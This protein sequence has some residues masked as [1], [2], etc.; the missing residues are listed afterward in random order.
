MV[1]RP[2]DQAGVVELA[3]V[4]LVVA[5]RVAVVHRAVAARRG[6]GDGVQQG[7]LRSDLGCHPRSGATYLR[8]NCLRP[9]A[10]IAGIYPYTCSLGERPRAVS[11]VAPHLFHAMERP[12]DFFAANCAFL[13][14][15]GVGLLVDAATAS[16]R[17]AS[18][19]AGAG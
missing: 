11:P 17:S 12:A 4:A 1:A 5:S 14:C 9:R 18:S 10:F 19:A 8:P 7:G 2:G 3:V 13:S 15:R 16:A 6:V